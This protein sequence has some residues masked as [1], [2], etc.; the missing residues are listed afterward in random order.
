MAPD[1]AVAGDEGFVPPPD[2]VP[3]PPPPLPLALVQLPSAN[4]CWVEVRV[5][6]KL[7]ASWLATD[8]TL[9]GTLETTASMSFLAP[10]PTLPIWDE[11]TPHRLAFSNSGFFFS[12]FLVRALPSLWRL[13]TNCCSWSA[14]LSVISLVPCTC[15]VPWLRTLVKPPAAV[16]SELRSPLNPSTALL[17]SLSWLPTCWMTP[18]IV[19]RSRSTTTLV[20]GSAKT[21]MAKVRRV[22]SVVNFILSTVW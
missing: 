10:S 17:S 14:S 22:N 12:R 13:E 5:E 2:F 11:M 15:C 6:A 8:W 20:G 19:A 16:A 21:P 1:P 18:W 3:L 4:V 9:W 7:P